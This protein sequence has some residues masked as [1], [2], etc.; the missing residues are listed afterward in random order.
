MDNIKQCEKCGKEFTK[1]INVSKKKWSTMRF[2]S[3]SCIRIGVSSP[4]KG[5][6]LSEERKLHLSKI[7]K[8]ITCNT[9]RTHIKKGQHLSVS[10]Q[11]K[12]G[13]IPWSKGKKLL[14]NTGEKNIRWKGG[15]TPEHQKLRHSP[16]MKSL[17]KDVFKRDNYT[18]T[19]CG[20]HRIPGDRVILEIHHIKPFA[21]CKELR[22]DENNVITLCA[23]CHRKTDTYGKNI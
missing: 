16:E 1:K 3:Q 15:V 11:F 14:C 12:K 9:G 6:P 21:T 7:L 13:M 10:T 20:R 8:G 4:N 22:F 23:E 19:E 2:C 18:C 5:I 17:R